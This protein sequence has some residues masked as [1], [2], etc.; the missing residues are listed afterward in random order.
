MTDERN[1]YKKRSFKE[2]QSV[3]LMALKLMQKISGQ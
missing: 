1:E 2:K 3:K